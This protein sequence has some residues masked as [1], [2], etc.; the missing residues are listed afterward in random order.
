MA[1][2]LSSLPDQAS[3][4]RN[5]LFVRWCFVNVVTENDERYR[6]MEFEWNVFATGPCETIDLNKGNVS[7]T[8]SFYWYKRSKKNWIFSTRRLSSKKLWAYKNWLDYAY[9]PPRVENLKTNIEHCTGNFSNSSLEL[10][11]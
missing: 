5:R 10:Y 11:L 7:E 9:K 1:K 3:L 4:R 8:F 2:H 6:R